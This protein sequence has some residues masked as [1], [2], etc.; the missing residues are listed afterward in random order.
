MASSHCTGPGV[1]TGPGM[2]L[3]YYILCRTFHTAPGLGTGPDPL[4]PAVLLPFPVPVLFPLPC[5]V[6]VL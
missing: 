5:I 4:S 6:N 2:A 3:G 1:G